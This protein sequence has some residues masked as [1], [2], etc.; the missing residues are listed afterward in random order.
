M[1]GR[2]SGSS[3]PFSSACADVLATLAL[4]SLASILAVWVLYPLVIAGL[5]ALR[6]APVRSADARSRVSVILATRDDDAAVAER[7]ADILR[8]EIVTARI[9]VV[10]ALDA[11]RAGGGIEYA[12]PRVIVVRGDEPGGKAATLNAGVR[13]S[14]GE[15]LVFTDTHQRFH[16]DAIA[17]LTSA[18][19]DP[20]VGC[21]SGCL[22][23]A[24]LAGSGS[25]R[26]ANGGGSLVGRYWLYE[27]WLRNAEARVHSTVGVTGAICALRRSLWAPL[28]SGLILDDVYTP[29][30]VVLDGWRVAFVDEARATETRIAVPGQEYRRKVRTLTGV[31]QLCAWLPGVLVPLRNPIWLQFVFH[32][33]LRLLTPYWMIAIA[34]WAAW[35]SALWLS[36]HL[37]VAL[38]VIA[39]AALVALVAR[40][41]VLRVVREGLLLQAAVIVG[42]IN[43][44]RGRWD[45]W[46][47]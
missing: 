29:M 4:V 21:A 24:P 22:D 41:R 46:R 28:P 26:G 20:R 19:A 27:R 13:A 42:T 10:V 17:L 39:L 37:A 33:L 12:D 43:G 38:A 7:V 44:F 45:V 11:T 18:F 47:R 14:S 25:A 8:A 16:R 32:K 2:A 5:A 31:I 6:H 9:E 35:T 23:L 36:A 34:V 15:L 1:A 3:R 40:H 30:R